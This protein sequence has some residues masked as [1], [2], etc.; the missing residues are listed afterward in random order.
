MHHS[1]REPLPRE[2]EVVMCVKGK[3]RVTGVDSVEGGTSGVPRPCKGIWMVSEVMH[4]PRE[5]ETEYQCF[6]LTVDGLSCRSRVQVALEPVVK[7]I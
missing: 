5:F 1:H 3:S 4:A 2:G 6:K 7:G